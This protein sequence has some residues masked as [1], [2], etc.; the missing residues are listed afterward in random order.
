MSALTFK[1]SLSQ[2]RL[3]E[4]KDLIYSFSE[5]SEIYIRATIR[6]IC[7]Y[8]IFCSRTQVIKPF[9]C[10]SKLNIEFIILINGKMP[11]TDDIH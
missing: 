5:N 3:P 8:R 6:G 2:Q 9:S 1:L 10:S 11:I 7:P 4:F